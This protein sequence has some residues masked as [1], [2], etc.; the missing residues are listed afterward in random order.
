MAALTLQYLEEHLLLDAE[1]KNF[2]KLVVDTLIKS[3]IQQLNNTTQ[4]NTEIVNINMQ[5]S[6][7]PSDGHDCLMICL[8]DE[9]NQTWC[10]HQ[11]ED[12]VEEG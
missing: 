12:I 10:I 1:F 5:F 6:L 4:S 2:G 8:K 7:K 9:N 3:A 11:L